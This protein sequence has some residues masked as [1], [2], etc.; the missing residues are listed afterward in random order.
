MMLATVAISRRALVAIMFVSSA[1]F[2]TPAGAGVALK[3]IAKT[4]KVSTLC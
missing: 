3:M 2:W 4:D 1:L